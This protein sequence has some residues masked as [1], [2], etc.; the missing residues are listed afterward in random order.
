[1]SYRIPV[2]ITNVFERKLQ[3]HVSGFGNEAVFSTDSAGWYIELD[4]QVC[5]YVGKEKP[6]EVIGDQL[7][8]RLGRIK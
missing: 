4:K 6:P 1:M 3:K 8:L 7:L 2:K 5:I